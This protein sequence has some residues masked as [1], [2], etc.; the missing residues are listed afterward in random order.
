MNHGKH[1]SLQD[2]I[3]YIKNTNF[4]ETSK[5]TSVWKVEQYRHPNCRKYPGL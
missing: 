5:Y 4:E 1:I 2:V 3:P